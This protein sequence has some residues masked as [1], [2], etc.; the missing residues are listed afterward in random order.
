MN[1]LGFYKNRQVEAGEVYYAG[2]KLRLAINFVLAS[3]VMFL[4]VM[5]VI[6]IFLTALKPDAEIVRFESIFPKTWTLDNFREI[7]HN[8]EE[9][10]I[11]QW[12][13]NSLIIS[14]C[15]SSRRFP[16]RLPDRAGYPG[17]TDGAGTRRTPPAP[18]GMIS[19]SGVSIQPRVFRIM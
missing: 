11:G 14:S 7:L 12:L 16:R 1:V 15:A 19:A 6:L 3:F 8:S 2:D 10:P 13:L 9:I 18:A 17:R 4:L 5:P